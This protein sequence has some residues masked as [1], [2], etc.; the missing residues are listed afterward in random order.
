VDLGVVKLA[1]NCVLSLY[2]VDAVRLFIEELFA[3]IL[4]AIL[5]LRH[6]EG[7]NKILAI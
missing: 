4:V 5:D 2:D 3:D 7:V 6:L 1:C